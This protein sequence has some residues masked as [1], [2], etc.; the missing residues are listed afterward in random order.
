M[1]PGNSASFTEPVSDDFGGALDKM[2][3]PTIGLPAV[4]SCFYV[5]LSMDDMFCKRT[6]LC[7][8]QDDQRAN[9]LQKDKGTYLR[10]ISSPYHDLSRES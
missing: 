5:E 9:L 1:P 7:I 4:K 3:F 6:Y 10:H 2:P 8:L